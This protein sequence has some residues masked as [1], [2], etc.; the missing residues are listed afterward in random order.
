MK[1]VLS[2]S[3]CILLVC[4]LLTDGYAGYGDGLQCPAG[5]SVGIP[6]EEMVK[7]CVSPD[8]GSYIMLFAGPMDNVPL[9]ELSDVW[10]S[11]L[12]KGG[13]PFQHKTFDFRG[14]VSG[15]P[16]VN[17]EYRGVVEGLNFD[18]N[19]IVVQR[20]GVCY[21]LVAFY[22]QGAEDIPVIMR[23]LTNWHLTGAD[24]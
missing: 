20:N 19:L 16:S 12:A 15:I 5:W 22:P 18:A 13:A 23:V 11:E 2:F 6:D 24:E 8:K 7:E 3:G 17:R 9:D 1:I 10:A 4:C 14:Q 21:A